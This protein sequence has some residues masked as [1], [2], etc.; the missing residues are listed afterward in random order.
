[1]SVPRCG[2]FVGIVAVALTFSSPLLADGRAVEL[3]VELGGRVA[4]AAA[5]PSCLIAEG[6]DGQLDLQITVAPSVGGGGVKGVHGSCSA[7]DGAPAPARARYRAVRFAPESIGRTGSFC[8]TFSPDGRTVVYVRTGTGLVEARLETEGWTEPEPLPFSGTTSRD[9]DPFLSPDGS[10]LFFWSTRPA[11]EGGTPAESSDLWVVERRADGWGAPR[12]VGAPVNDAG[13]EPFP[14]VAADGTLYFGSLRPGGRGGFDLYRARPN[15]DGYAKPENLGIAINSP[16]GELDGYISPDQ[17]VLVFASDRPG[18]YGK[19][20]LYVS[21][22]MV[23]GWSPA[24]NLGPAVNGPDDEFCPQL[25]RD[26]RLLLFS[27]SGGVYQI[28]AAALDDATP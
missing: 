2:A 3:A 28:D 14:A 19:L 17:K 4:M 9:G 10:R 27:R 25:T 5:L 6:R 18:G 1:M 24:R 11:T 23:G 13:G 15:A 8:P 12:K 26:G 7:P 21:H 16:A 22:R 20:D